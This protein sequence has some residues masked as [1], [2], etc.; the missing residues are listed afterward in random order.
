MKLFGHGVVT[1]TSP[2]MTAQDASNGE[3]KPFQRAVHLDGLEGIART[4]RSETTR[5]GKQR[6][7]AGTI[8]IDG[9]KKEKREE[10]RDA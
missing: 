6:R 8:E 3:I 4:R 2:R 1:T 9:E 5:G 7:D 10:G